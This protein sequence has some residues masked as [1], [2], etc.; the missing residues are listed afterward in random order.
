M[1]CFDLFSDKLLTKCCFEKTA[2][3]NF[4]S[5]NQK[6]FLSIAAALLGLSYPTYGAASGVGADEAVIRYFADSNSV[7]VYGYEGKDTAAAVSKLNAGGLSGE[8]VNVQ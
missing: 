2:T 4:K 5:I 6:K 8:V 3:K 1:L 7:V